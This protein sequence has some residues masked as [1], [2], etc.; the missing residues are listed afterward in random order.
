LFLYASVRSL[1][2]PAVREFV[3]F[4]LANGERIARA[5]RYTALSASSYRLGLAHVRSGA[6]GSAWDG[7]V[8]VGVTQK[9]VEMRM[10]AL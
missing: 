1:Q 8:P 3:E 2:K 10:A 4:T 7:V 6:K 9:A 5:G